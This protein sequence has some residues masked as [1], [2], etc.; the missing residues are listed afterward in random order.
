LLPLALLCP[1]Y[2]IAE[3]TIADCWNELLLTA[4]LL[5]LGC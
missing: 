1:C 3:L 2:F 5:M 4:E